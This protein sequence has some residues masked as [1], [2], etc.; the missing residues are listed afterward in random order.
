MK[1]YTTELSLLALTKKLSPLMSL[2][3]FLAL[4]FLT[5][6]HKNERKVQEGGDMGVP[7]ASF[8]DV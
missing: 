1:F 2:L 3:R 6:H 5:S 4:G 8:C 7:M